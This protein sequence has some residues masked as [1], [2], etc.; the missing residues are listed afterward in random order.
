MDPDSAKVNE[1]LEQSSL[2]TDPQIGSGVLDDIQSLLHE[3]RELSHDHFRLA[4]LETQRAGQSFVTML[5]AGVMVA[6]LLNG[7][8]LGLLTAGAL[9]LVENGIKVS[10]AILLTVVFNLLLL[11]ICFGVIRRQSHYLHFPALLRS[12]KPKSAT[13]QDKENR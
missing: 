6:L 12:L 3:M 8:W 2:H 13:R 5:V 4:A 9:W 11:L 10:S 7:A 1:S